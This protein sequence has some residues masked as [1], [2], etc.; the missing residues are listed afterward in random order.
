MK[1]AIIITIRIIAIIVLLV[2][3]YMLTVYLIG[4]IHDFSVRDAIKRLRDQSFDPNATD[5]L[6]EVLDEYKSLY[7]ENDEV[8]GWLKI[9]DTSID[10]VVMYAPDTPQKY[11]HRDFYGKESYRGCLYVDE[12]CDVLHSDN[13]IIYGHHMKDGSMFGDLIDY[14]SESFYNK[15]KTVIFDS[16]YEKHTYEVVAAIKTSI[17]PEGVEGFRY[18][19]YTGVNDTEKFAQYKEFI[20][21]NALYDTGVE[22]NEGDRLLTLSTCAYHTEDGRFIVVAKCID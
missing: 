2:S 15:H 13:I 22:L 1:K 19:M 18:H 17:L 10:Y 21:K 5:P 20:A 11:L 8:I 4:D 9:P 16:I 7:A 6:P 14:Q 12:K 3:L